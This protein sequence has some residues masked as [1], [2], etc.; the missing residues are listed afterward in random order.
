M[1]NRKINRK[2][3][4]VYRENA[5]A[6]VA[7][8][9]KHFEGKGC[10][11]RFGIIDE[12]CYDPEN[13]ILFIAKET[14]GKNFCLLGW[15]RKWLNDP[16]E[17]TSHPRLWQNISRW[18]K[19]IRNSYL[20]LEELAA[21]KSI[22][23]LKYIA[24]TNVNKVGGYPSSG[25]AFRKLTKS[26]IA[27]QLLLREIEIIQPKWIVLCG[28]EGVIDAKD[29]SATIITMSHPSARKSN[30]KMLDELVKQLEELQ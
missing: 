5:E 21:E 23:G 26:D 28:L 29:T 16:R 9:N 8:W 11:N 1:K 30:R 13:G 27:R 17:G 22:E 25:R 2:L 15:L 20:N 7:E 12:E 6:F 19:L 10:M 4:E 18:A 3:A 24:F 14:R